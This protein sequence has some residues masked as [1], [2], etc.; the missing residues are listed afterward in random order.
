MRVRTR[1]FY[2]SIMTPQ[3]WIAFL[4]W[5]VGLALLH[6][7]K[8]LFQDSPF[9]Y[10]PDWTIWSSK[11][12]Q[13]SGECLV[14]TVNVRKFKKIYVIINNVTLT[15]DLEIQGQTW[16]NTVNIISLT[17]CG[18]IE[19][20]VECYNKLM[21]RNSKNVRFTAWMYI[22]I[23]REQWCIYPLVKLAMAPWQK[24]FFFYIVK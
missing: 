5:G 18:I 2:S 20:C 22:D 14:S 21:S 23:D 24:N 10:T 9:N 4:H 8:G 19:T 16:C 12:Q 13:F 7:K 11:F 3:L 6:C 15:F 17:I 1:V